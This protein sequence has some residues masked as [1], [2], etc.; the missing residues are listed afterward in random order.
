MERPTLRQLE[1]AVALD[2]ARSFS[3]AALECHVS[4]PGLSAQIAE[5][6]RRLGV[7]LFER[8]RNSTTPTAVGSEVLARARAILRDLDDVIRVADVH[9]GTVAGVLRVAAIPTLAPYLLSTV[10]HELRRLWPD[11][12]LELAELRT[13]DLV[14]AATEGSVDLGLLATP[15]DVGGLAAVDLAFEPFMVAMAQSNPLAQETAISADQLAE[16]E[17]W[18]LEEGHCLREHALAVCSLVG[19]DN[20]RDVHRTSLAVLAQM[21]AMADA[22][23]LLPACAVGVEA[24]EGSGLSTVALTQPEVG[25]TISMVWRP[26]DPRGDLYQRAFPLVATALRT[27]IDR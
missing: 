11:V 9:R 13:A 21:V 19:A 12:H 4:Q 3:R 8:T 10:A 15:V 7:A 1:Y 16:L 5:L 24:R 22:V 23:T 18:L 26:G 14:R 27:H 25:R 6:E 20:H 17:I 2:D